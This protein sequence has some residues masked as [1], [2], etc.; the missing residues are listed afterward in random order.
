MN[1]AA[2]KIEWCD[3]VWNPV[4]GCKKV[5]AGCMNCYAEVYANR[6]W[7]DRK[8]NDVA[9]N[10][11][12]LLEPYKW[13]K[14]QRIF[15]N[16][17]S[18]IFHESVSFE[19]IRHVYYTMITNFRHTFIILTKRPAQALAF[20]EWFAKEEPFAKQPGRCNNIWFGVSVENQQTADERIPL[21]LQ[22]PAA[23]RFISA[24]PLID[25]LD[26]EKIRQRS[27]GWPVFIDWVIVGGESGKNARPMYPDWARSLRDQCK[28]AGVPFFFKQW[29]EYK[30][31]A[32]NSE[33]V[34]MWRLGKKKAGRLLDGIEHNEYPVI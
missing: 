16:S 31:V 15:V 7:K 3:K 28:K 20:Y 8:F 22:I 27:L 17:M 11:G 10:Y 6:F 32:E 13:K 5:S 30:G 29:G 2:T 23:V 9:L 25:Y 19:F 33:K 21:L 24:E 12:K 26:L 14:P 18:D 1:M 34:V 4:S